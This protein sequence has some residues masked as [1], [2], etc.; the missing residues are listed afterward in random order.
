ML[1][2]RAAILIL[3]ASCSVASASMFFPTVEGQAE[4]V[5]GS[6]VV[7]QA[8]DYPSVSRHSAVPKDERVTMEFDV[9]SIPDDAQV[10]SASLRFYV[11]GRTWYEPA[12]SDPVYPFIRFYGYPGNGQLDDL[13]GWISS[14]HL[15]DSSTI[16]SS[17]SYLVSLDAAGVESLLGWGDYL[18]ITGY[19][20][21]DYC[22]ATIRSSAVYGPAAGPYLVV[23]YIPEPGIVS[24]LTVA[25]LGLL[26]RKRR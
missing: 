9:S 17:G 14:S 19:M 13:D 16:S 12:G 10:T 25:A 20:G 18:G 2:Y 3:A 15:G 8:G 1:N 23:A 7:T 22:G 4:L 24:L 26:R 11:G 6:I 5:S 21:E